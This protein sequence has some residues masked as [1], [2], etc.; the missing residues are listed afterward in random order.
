M[1][2]DLVNM[3][4]GA[5]GILETKGL[6][7]A[8]SLVMVPSI[9]VMSGF[10]GIHAHIPMLLNVYNGFSAMTFAAGLGPHNIKFNFASSMLT[11]FILGSMLGIL[12]GQASQTTE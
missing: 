7:R 1:S 10:V 12:F 9:L 6:L 2:L 8:H 3:C 4:W 5:L 11:T